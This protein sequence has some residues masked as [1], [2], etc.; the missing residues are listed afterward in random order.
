MNK[1]DLIRSLTIYFYNSSFPTTCRNC[2]YEQ[3]EMQ[4]RTCK[5]IDM[6]KLSFDKCEEIT[7][8]IITLIGDNYEV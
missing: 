2:R 6:W 1:N 7:D 4:C 8:D 5:I 3:T